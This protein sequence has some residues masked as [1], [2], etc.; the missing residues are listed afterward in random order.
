MQIEGKKVLVVGIARSGVAAARVLV[1]RGAVVT[2]N[3]MK[4]ESDLAAE[5]DELRR[6]G[7]MLSLGGHPEALFLNADLIVVSDLRAFG[8]LGLLGGCSRHQR[9]KQHPDGDEDGGPAVID[10]H[11]CGE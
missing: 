1:S 11:I 7:V 2:A 9:G 3:D 8:R 5:V 6:L 4:L 10:T